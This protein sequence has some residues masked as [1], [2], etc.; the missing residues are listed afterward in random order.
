MTSTHSVTVRKIQKDCI[1]PL[2]RTCVPVIRP[3]ARVRPADY[4][5]LKEWTDFLSL[6]SI[7][8]LP[9]QPFLPLPFCSNL[10]IYSSQTVKAEKSDCG[11]RIRAEDREEERESQDASRRASHV[12]TSFLNLALDCLKFTCWRARRRGGPRPEGV[13]EE[14]EEEGAQA[15]VHPALVVERHLVPKH[16]QARRGGRT[17]VR[18]H[19]R[20]EWRWW[21]PFMES[22][23]GSP[24]EK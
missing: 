21:W 17:L 8:R 7:T 19:R 1:E 5:R 16:S 11:G 9:C 4:S 20:W 10:Q 24:V 23:E 13:E 6:S 12:R 15:Q 2:D 14:G 3:E 22:C 18:C